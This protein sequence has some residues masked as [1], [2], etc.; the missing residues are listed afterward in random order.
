MFRPL[1]FTK[2]YAMAAAAAL[3]L[4]LVPILMG[5][6]IRGRIL[7]EER[8]PINRF[9]IRVYH[10]VARFVLA[11]SRAVIV[12]AAA[13]VAVTVVPLLRLGSEFM[14]PLYEGDLLYM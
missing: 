4:T 13:L 6:W 3:S 8:N 9:L 14:P 1:A 7:P 5:Y 11:H 2:T 12:A 10:P